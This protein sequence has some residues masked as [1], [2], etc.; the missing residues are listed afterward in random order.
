MYRKESSSISLRNEN[1]FKNLPPDHFKDKTVNNT[2]DPYVEYR[3]EKQFRLMISYLKP[4]QEDKILCVGVGSG[5]EIEVLN[6]YVYKIY[7]VDISQGFLD[8]CNNR[9]GDRFEGYLCNLEQDKTIYDSNSFDKVVCLNV[10]PY[11]SKSGVHNFFCEMSRIMK[12]GGLMFLF[13]LNAKFPYAEALQKQIFKQRLKDSRAIYFYRPLSDYINI[14]SKYD[15]IISDLEG[16]DFYSDINSR[17]LRFL[18][19]FRWRKILFKIM[20]FGGKTVLKKY[21]RSLYLTI[22]K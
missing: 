4:S 6:N 16:G 17:F 8:Y 3:R 9:Y 19:N 15:F 5:R 7:G 10:L 12:K 21:Y 2:L 18:F 11:F 20:E 22:T 1:F 13:T 14:L